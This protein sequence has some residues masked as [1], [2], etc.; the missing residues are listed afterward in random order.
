M[1]RTTF[2]TYFKKVAGVGPFTYLTEWRM[3]RAEYAL[4]EDK[5]SVSE[6]AQSLGY[7]SESA[8]SHAFKRVTGWHRGTIG[9]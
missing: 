8:F 4:R 1:S 6:L 5:I 2:A 9:P 7:T 3:R